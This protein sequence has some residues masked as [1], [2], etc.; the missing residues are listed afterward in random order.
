MAAYTP[1]PH[2]AA[3][4]QLTYKEREKGGNKGNS[5]LFLFCATADF[6]SLADRTE[7]D[8]VPP[9]LSWLDSAPG[10]PGSGCGGDGNI[11]GLAFKHRVG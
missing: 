10:A 11:G 9:L 2:A 1:K 4:L 6:Y 7:L 8:R 5:P 3:F